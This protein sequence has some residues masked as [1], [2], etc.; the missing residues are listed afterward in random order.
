VI[1]IKQVDFGENIAVA[2]TFCNGIFTDLTVKS[3]IASTYKWY[4]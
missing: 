3:K 1:L 2:F 4:I